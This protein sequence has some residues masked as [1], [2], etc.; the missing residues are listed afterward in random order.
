[1]NKGDTI[2]IGSI[3]MICIVS[4]IVL[5]TIESGNGS[6]V[7]ALIQV[8]GEHYKS[9]SLKDHQNVV[10]D[11]E[12]KYN[13]IIVDS[14]GIYM[15]SASCDNQDCVHQEKISVKNLGT[16]VLGKWIICLPNRVSIEVVEGDH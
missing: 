7:F 10:I 14:E 11:Q 4:I 3:I 1:M 2:I 8:D 9:L 6:E 15:E 13:E 5:W 16:R 12:G